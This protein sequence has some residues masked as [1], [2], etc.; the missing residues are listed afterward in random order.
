MS[1]RIIKVEIVFLDVLTV[2]AFRGGEAEEPLLEDRVSAVPEGG[3]E[4][5]ELITVADPGDAVLAPAI[6]LAA[7]QVVRQEVPGVA[8]GAVVLADGG[9]GAVADIR[10]PPPPA[11]RVVADLPEPLVF[12]GRHAR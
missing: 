6:G 10:A 1:G 8:V 3:R 11:G 9:P 7:G 2:I 12:P 5:E 4:H